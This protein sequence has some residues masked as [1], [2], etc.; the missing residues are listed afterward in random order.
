MHVPK[1]APTITTLVTPRVD[2]T[3][4]THGSASLN[5]GI[6]SSHDPHASFGSK[7]RHLPEDIF[8]SHPTTET[9]WENALSEAKRLMRYR[10]PCVE[11]CGDVPGTRVRIADFSSL[12]G[13]VPFSQIRIGHELYNA[14]TSRNMREMLLAH[15]LGHLELWN[16]PRHFLY[17]FKV[18]PR[19]ARE[20]QDVN[21]IVY[22]ALS[23]E[24]PPTFAAERMRRC[25]MEFLDHQ[26]GTSAKNIERHID[27][28]MP[29]IRLES[30]PPLRFLGRKW[31]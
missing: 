9:D 24:M 29:V 31:R 30:P 3:A 16:S 28:F 21:H 17:T 5:P 18:L 13:Q 19:G 15:E 11:I 6:E 23:R 14:P 10:G 4:A 2:P 20:E 8:S 25:A 1:S 7:H 12:P 22:I 27:T 26:T